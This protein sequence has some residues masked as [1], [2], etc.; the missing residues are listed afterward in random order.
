MASQNIDWQLPQRN[1]SPVALSAVSTRR[2][3]TKTSAANMHKMP[4]QEPPAVSTSPSSNETKDIPTVRDGRS[5]SLPNNQ[6]FRRSSGGSI[7]GFARRPTR[8][9]TVKTYQA[10]TRLNW[11]PGA[12]PGVDTTKDTLG[13]HALHDVSKKHPASTINDYRLMSQC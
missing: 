6:Y 4:A 3:T 1:R 5:S 2:R 12:E 13:A 9:N 11:Q 8:S 10:P 7:P